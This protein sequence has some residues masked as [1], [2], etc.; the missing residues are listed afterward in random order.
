MFLK[1]NKSY[2]Y[3]IVYHLDSLIKIDQ[4]YVTFFFIL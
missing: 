4:L 1:R 2:V 3:W